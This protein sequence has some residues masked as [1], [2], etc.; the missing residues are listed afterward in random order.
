MIR[1]GGQKRHDWPQTACA[2]PLRSSSRAAMATPGRARLARLGTSFE[3][4][5][6]WAAQ[7]AAQV[8]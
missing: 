3:K 8:E 5:M 6:N 7:W 1:A 2:G 4:F